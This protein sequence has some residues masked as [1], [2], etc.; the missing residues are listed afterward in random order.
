MEEQKEQEVTKQEKRIIK[1]IFGDINKNNFEQ[2]R[3]L[4]NLSLPVR[5]QN[6]FYARILGKLRHGRFAY[7]ND[8]IVGAISWKYDLIEGHRA[9]YIMTIT[10]FEDYKRYGIGTQLLQELINIHKDMKEID[11]IYLHVQINNELALSF[12]TKNKFEIVKTIKDYY[13]DIEPKDAY[14]V[15]LKLRD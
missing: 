9:V 8:I 6:G 10:V 1:V 13:T 7:Y 12:Y 15:K 3:Q 14:L 5:Y 2:M 11:F 4:N